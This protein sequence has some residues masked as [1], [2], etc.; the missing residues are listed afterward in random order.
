[1][2]MVQPEVSPWGVLTPSHQKSRWEPDRSK[3]GNYSIHDDQ[4]SDAPRGDWFLRFGTSNVGTTAG[5]T[6]EVVEVLVRRRVDICCVQE[7][8]WNGSGA[9]MVK[10]RQRQKYKFMW[11]GARKA[12][13]VLVSCFLRS[14]Q[15]V[16]ECD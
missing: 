1:M 14:L 3:G 16:C 13:M 11:Q 4:M 15:T 6:G 5:R 9:R 2:G 12:C 8:R 10:G 7:M